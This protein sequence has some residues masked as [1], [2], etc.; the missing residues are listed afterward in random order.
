VFCSS[1]TFARNAVFFLCASDA[2]GNSFN[3]PEKLTLL[4]LP[5]R[6]ANNPDQA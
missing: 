2:W 4:F 3:L 6:Q 1:K 5:P